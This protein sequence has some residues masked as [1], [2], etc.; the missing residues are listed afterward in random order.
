MD[1]KEFDYINVVPL[2]DIMLVLL[3]I[4]LTTSTLVATGTLPLQLPQA[5]SDRE[6]LR[7]MQIIEIDR[8]GALFLNQ[9]PLCLGELDNALARLD[10]SDPILIRADKKL[11]LQT[12]VEVLD[13]VK[14]HGFVRVSLQTE[15]KR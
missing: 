5:T 11:V 14:E 3:T 2:V 4:V 1:E 7:K 10:A 15:A 12:F 13:K 6:S 9:Q 8:S